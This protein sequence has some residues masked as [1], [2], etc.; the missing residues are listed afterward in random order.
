MIG[1]HSAGLMC[2]RVCTERGWVVVA[3]DCAHFYENIELGKPFVICFDLGAMMNGFNTIRLLADSPD[4]IVPG[5]DP[6]VLQY[7]TPVSEELRGIAHRL[8][9]PP[10]KG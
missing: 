7:Y 8:D 4:H 1:G 2:V 3:S 10:T 6:L 9:V 5:H